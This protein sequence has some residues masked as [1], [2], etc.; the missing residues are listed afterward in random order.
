MRAAGKVMP[1]LA[2]L[3]T[4]LPEP[5]RPPV[6]VVW[7][8]V[9]EGRDER[10][11]RGS[12]LETTTTITDD[13]APVPFLVAEPAALPLPDMAAAGGGVVVCVWVCGAFG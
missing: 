5:P 8:C 7:L 1:A 3:E 13:D 9:V 10:L 11:S 6:L 12:V 2:D 4:A